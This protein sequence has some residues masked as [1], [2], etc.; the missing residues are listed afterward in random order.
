V[1]RERAADLYGTELWIGEGAGSGGGLKSKGQKAITMSKEHL[2][3]F[4]VENFKRFDSLEL[5]DIG[6]FN[7][8]VGDNNV[9]KTS[10]LEALLIN[11]N[12]LDTITNLRQT[13]LNRGFKIPTSIIRDEKTGKD[14][15]DSGFNYFDIFPK[16]KNKPLA[17]TLSTNKKSNVSFQIKLDIDHLTYYIA[18]KPLH[19]ISIY[20]NSKTNYVPFVPYALSAGEDLIVYYS[21]L[22]NQ[23]RLAVKSFMSIIKFF[24]PDIEDITINSI[25]NGNTIYLGLENRN[26]WVPI[27]AFGDGTK[28]LFRIALEISECVGKRLMIDEID[29]GMHYSRM[30]GFLRTVFQMALK[31]NVQLFMTTHSRECQQAFAE[32]FEDGEM[33]SYQDKVRQFTLIEKPDGQV[34]AINRNF[35]QLEFALETDNET[36]GGK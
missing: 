8:I 30:K 20:A 1:A 27:Q 32:V 28:R 9:G 31:G 3:Y 4:K 23:G 7:L 16:D 34:K 6:Q 18:S 22:V 36:R 15:P 35:D 10:L 25:P 17:I 29:A 14:L 26:D 21:N 24:I 19:R 33:K 5:T 13:A 11:E 2:T 12:A